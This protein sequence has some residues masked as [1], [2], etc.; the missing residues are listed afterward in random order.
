[1]EFT[2]AMLAVVALLMTLGMGI[3]TWR[4]LRDERRR[5]A[6]RIA[7]LAAELDGYRAAPPSLP[8]PATPSPFTGLGAASAEAPVPGWAAQGA[9][10]VAAAGLVLAVVLITAIGL[11]EGDGGEPGPPA[12]API[13]L[14]ALA[15]E[16][17]G[18]ALAISGSV[19]AAEATVAGPLAVLATALDAGGSPVA[20]RR[21]AL[22]ELVPGAV[23][24]FVV[25]VPAAGVS[26]YRISFLRDE[27]TVPHVDRRSSAR[28][29]DASS[30]GTGATGGAS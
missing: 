12:R 7:A 15:H 16:P 21:V 5:S 25:E 3:V 14:L 28:A 20:S 18:S 11:R 22:P 24:P 26:R 19:R 1:M 4:L 29:G 17:A 13:E 8:E 2:L 9:G 30:E 23:L 6:A 27:A 10:L